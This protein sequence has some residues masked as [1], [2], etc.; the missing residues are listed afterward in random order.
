MNKIILADAGHIA[1][2]H[3]SKI[4]ALKGKSIL[5]TGSTGMIMSYM[6]EILAYLNKEHSLEMK[7]YLHGR[8]MQRLKSRHND[9][10]DM[11]GIFFLD[12]DVIENIPQNINFDYIV[13][14]ASPAGTKAFLENPVGTI[15]PNVYGIRNILEYAKGHNTKVCFLSSNA[16]Y[17]TIN[18]SLISETDYGI[19]DPLGERACY[20]ESKR[21]AEQLCVAYN[22]QYGIKASIA[23]IPFTYGPTYDLKNDTRALA[24][25]IKCIIENK[26]IEIFEDATP[27]QYTYA[28]D[29][30]SA[31]LY[32]MDDEKAAG[33]AFNICT[34]AAMNMQDI[35]DTML[36]ACS[37][38]SK[39]RLIIKKDQSEYYFGKNKD[40]NLSLMDNTKLINLGWHECYDFPSGLKQTILGAYEKYTCRG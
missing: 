31:I 34:T 38:K 6:A 8:N 36:L 27:L 17:G 5:L 14:G 2:A 4:L 39:S 9:I 30:V 21:L 3:L 10:V 12:F 24:R 25:F 20:I 40:I 16:I 33:E 22:K 28:A 26:D 23:R 32:M 1:S 18:K 19:V 13:H 29:V 7:I 37:E 11:E 35:I 15:L